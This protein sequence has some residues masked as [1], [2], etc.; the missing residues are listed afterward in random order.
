VQS[1]SDLSNGEQFIVRR[2]RRRSGKAADGDAANGFEFADEKWQVR[3]VQF[4][5]KNEREFQF[6]TNGDSNRAPKK[7]R[8]RI[9]S[10]SWAIPHSVR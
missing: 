3:G 8:A 9:S 10:T 2:R 6:L 4:T 7:K 5:G 1:V